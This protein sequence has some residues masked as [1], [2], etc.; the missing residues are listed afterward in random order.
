MELKL[1]LSAAVLKP[2]VAKRVATRQQR[3][4]QFTPKIEISANE[5]ASMSVMSLTCPDS[6][7]LLAQVS[8]SFFEHRVRVHSARIATFG[9]R[10]EDFF[11]L[12]DVNGKALTEPAAAALASAIRGKLSG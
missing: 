10:V 2:R 9:E 1:A 11:S 5:D 3:H 6:F 12:S 7:G 4:F 8:L